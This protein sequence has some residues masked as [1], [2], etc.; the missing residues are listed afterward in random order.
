M[1]S[2]EQIACLY[3][4]EKGE[5]SLGGRSDFSEELSRMHADARLETEA[6][7][8]RTPKNMMKRAK[9]DQT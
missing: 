7:A 5:G 4:A 8:D 6:L 3:E 1:S 2:T 9:L